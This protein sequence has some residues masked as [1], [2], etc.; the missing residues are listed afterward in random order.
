MDR[1][2]RILLVDDEATITRTLKLY[3]EATGAYE[4]RAENQGAAAIQTARAFKPD[5]I[6]L[7]VVMPDIDGADVAAQLRSDETLKDT[8]IVFLTALVKKKEVVESGGTIGGY[9]FIAKPLEPEQVIAVIESQ[10]GA[11][12]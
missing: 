1:K 5:L 11:S 8:P 9:P 12:S 2:K 7:D 6:L 4:V 10:T 3:L